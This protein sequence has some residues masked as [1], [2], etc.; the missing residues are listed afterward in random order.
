MADTGRDLVAWLIRTWRADVAGIPAA[1]VAAEVGVGRSTVSNWES[2]R[3]N[4]DPEALARLD[5]LFDAG[6]ALVDLARALRTPE[7]LDARTTWWNN[8]PPS[9]GPAWAWI[10]PA[11]GASSVCGCGGVRSVSNSTG[12]VT[13]GA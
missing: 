9:C 7:G 4:P 3:R 12:R 11:D 5:G 8:F 2:G 10:R 1:R 13:P 6:G